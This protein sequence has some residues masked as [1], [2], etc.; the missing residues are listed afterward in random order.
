MKDMK[1]REQKEAKLEQE[2]EQLKQQLAALK[3]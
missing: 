2:K 1:N 3:K